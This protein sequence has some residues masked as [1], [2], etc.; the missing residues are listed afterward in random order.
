MDAY[1]N[2]V[3]GIMF[4]FLAFAAVFLMFKIWGSFRRGKAR[5]QR[6][7]IPRG[8]PSH[9]R[10]LLP[11]AVPAAD[12]TDGASCV[13]LPG[14]VLDAHGG[15]PDAGG[16]HRSAVDRQALD[17]SFLQ[18]LLRRRP[19]SGL[20]PVV[21]HDDGREP[22]GALR[23]QGELLEPGRGG[24]SCPRLPSCVPAATCC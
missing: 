18:A 9:H 19:V 6:S 12:G 11:G 2:A 5:Q 16:V 8:Y 4:L 20:H 13:R 10:P 3:L 24:R 14:G 17:H 21:V 22:V 1:T 23:L 15:P 7:P